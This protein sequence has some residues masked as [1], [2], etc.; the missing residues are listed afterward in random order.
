LDIKIDEFLIVTDWNCKE[1]WVYGYRKN[2]EKEKGFFPK[3][4]VKCCRNNNNG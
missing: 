4:F 2:N 1:G 3:V